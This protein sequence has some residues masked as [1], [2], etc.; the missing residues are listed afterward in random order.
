VADARE[1][2]LNFGWPEVARQTCEVY[3][4]LATAAMSSR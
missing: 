2:I 4:A 1:H 3:E